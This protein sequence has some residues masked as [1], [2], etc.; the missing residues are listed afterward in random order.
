MIPQAVK[1]LST[2]LK[3][4]PPLIFTCLSESSELSTVASRDKRQVRKWFVSQ[5]ERNPDGEE[6][7]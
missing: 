2:Y 3:T 7:T 6:E 1:L 4:P 5:Y